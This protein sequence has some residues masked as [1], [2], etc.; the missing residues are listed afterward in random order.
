MVL[1]KI[2]G[3]SFFDQ[4]IFQALITG[5]CNLGTQFNNFANDFAMKL[6]QVTC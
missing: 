5:K 4:L 6:I 2:I 1:I 3:D